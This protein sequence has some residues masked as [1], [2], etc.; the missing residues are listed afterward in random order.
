[1]G[2]G[3]GGGGG[4]GGGGGGG[5]GVKKRPGPAP[6]DGVRGEVRPGRRRIDRRGAPERAQPSARIS[7]GRGGPH[8]SMGPRHVHVEASGVPSSPRGRGRS[9]RLAHLRDPRGFPSRSYSSG[10]V[11]PQQLEIEGPRPKLLDSPAFLPSTPSQYTNA[12]MRRRGARRGCKR[13]WTGTCRARRDVGGRGDPGMEACTTSRGTHWG[14]APSSEKC[15]CGG[16]SVSTTLPRT[17]V[18]WKVIPLE[19]ER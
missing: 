6:R 15:M 2:G 5:G 16:I 13:G 4:W 14:A 17:H 3:G 10:G 9:P 19:M 1:L 11:L 7:R 8:L 12:C 18:R